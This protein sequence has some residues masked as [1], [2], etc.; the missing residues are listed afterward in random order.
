MATTGIEDRTSRVTAGAD[1]VWKGIAAYAVAAVTDK[2]SLGFRGETFHDEG[3]VRLGTDTSARLS[4]G[5]LTPAY[6]ITS[7]VLVRGEL[8]FDSANQPI[9]SKGRTFSDSQRSVGANIIF[10]Y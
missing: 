5:T 10:V 4:E 7:H 3:G 2:F 6:K 1:A 8:R 9:L